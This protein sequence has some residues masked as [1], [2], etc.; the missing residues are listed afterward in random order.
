M[1]QKKWLAL[2]L[3]AVMVIL[4]APLALAQAPGGLPP[5]V[6]AAWKKEPAL[7]QADIDTYIKVIPDMAEAMKDQSKAPAVVKKSGLTET[8]FA[9]VFTKIGIAQA[10]AAD[11]NDRSQL[12]QLPAIIRPTETELGLINK[13]LN[14]ISEAQEKALPSS[15]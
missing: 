8:R 12:D 7:T 11:I 1:I 13:T 9:Y 6:E 4:A 3:A 5:E 10:L 15:K 2:A 14:A